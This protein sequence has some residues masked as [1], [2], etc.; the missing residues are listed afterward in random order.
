[1]DEHVIGHVQAGQ[2]GLRVRV[3]AQPGDSVAELAD[4]V[5]GGERR[6]IELLVGLVAENLATDQALGERPAPYR[7]AA[8]DERL[9]PGVNGE[10][11]MLLS[12]DDPQPSPQPRPS[13]QIPVAQP[14][15]PRHP[16]QHRGHRDRAPGRHDQA[17][18][19]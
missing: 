13:P 8:A 2:P 9:E 7:L 5:L 17:S 6:G 4:Q 14:P 18:A 11:V 12:V 10:R 19:G 16:G 15:E 3:G 1:V